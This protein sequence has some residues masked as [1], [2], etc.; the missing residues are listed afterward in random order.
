MEKYNTVFA[1]NSFYSLNHFTTLDDKTVDKYIDNDGDR[2]KMKIGIREMKEFQFYY[3]A[4]SS[5]LQELGMEKV[6]KIL[7]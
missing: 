5:L 6:C 3:T 2:E 4:T 7:F 1:R